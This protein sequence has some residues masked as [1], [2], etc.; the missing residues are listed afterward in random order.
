[1]M[2]QAETFQQ[3]CAEFTDIASTDSNLSPS[4]LALVKEMAITCV[5]FHCTNFIGG[6][7]V[8]V[9]ADGTALTPVLGR[10]L[11]LEIIGMVQL[12][13]VR[14]APHLTVGELD[15]L[16]RLGNRADA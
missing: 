16:H 2:T 13:L 7:F 3:S 12:D 1:M 9:F 6:L 4:E 5:E 8:Y 14:K 11:R 15:Q 10:R